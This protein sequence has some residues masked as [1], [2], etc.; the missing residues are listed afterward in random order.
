[1]GGPPELYEVVLFGP[2]GRRTFMRFM[3]ER[4]L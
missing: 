3:G 4:E 2:N 1:M